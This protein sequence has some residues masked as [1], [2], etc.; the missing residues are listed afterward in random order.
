[1]NQKDKLL[2]HFKKGGKL[3]VLSALKKFGVYALSQR[4][5]DLTRE[6]YRI[7]KEWKTTKTNKRIRQYS[8]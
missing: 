1:M 3:T 8:L 5:T 2:N 4:V 7:K 6:G